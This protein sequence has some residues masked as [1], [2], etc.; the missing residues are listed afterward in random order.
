MSSLTIVLTTHK[1]DPSYLEATLKSYHETCNHPLDLLVHNLA[2]EREDR[3]LLLVGTKE[4]RFL[5]EE[6]NIEKQS[7]GLRVRVTHATR[8][9]LE[10]ADGECILLQDDIKFSAGWL[11]KLADHL[12]ALEER[13]NAL[14]SLFSHR[15]SEVEGL[16][17]WDP[18]TY[19]GLQGMFFGK[20]ARLATIAQAFQTS[21]P[22]RLWP[23]ENNSTA[24]GADVRLQRFLLD[25]SAFT[26]FAIYPSLVQH[27]GTVSSITSKM[28]D[29]RSPTFQESRPPVTWPKFQLKRSR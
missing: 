11:G 10:M 1:R 4:T 12:A 14:V 16:V 19:W 3:D 26:L 8:L 29:M 24:P 15:Q 23:T 18:K 22:G 7:L 27:T 20:A 17:K 2:S 5:T 21:G 25:N 6:E 9:A 13:D 28:K